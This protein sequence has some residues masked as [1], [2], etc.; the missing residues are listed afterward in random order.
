MAEDETS[1]D[2]LHEVKADPYRITDR[3]QQ[4]ILRD[5]FRSIKLGVVL[6]SLLLTIALIF[7]TNLGAGPIVKGS[8]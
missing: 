6:A 5:S 2:D 7:D 4:W 3:F 1:L 8:K